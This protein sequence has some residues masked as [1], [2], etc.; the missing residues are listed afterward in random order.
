MPDHKK[1]CTQQHL[2]ALPS[3]LGDKT[4]DGILKVI[5]GLMIQTTQAYRPAIFECQML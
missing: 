4:L 2:F 5:L 3:Q 1:R